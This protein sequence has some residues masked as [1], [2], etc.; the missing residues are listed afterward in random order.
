MEDWR[1]IPGVEI[2]GITGHARHGKDELARA[3]IRLLPGAERFALSDAV[4]AYGRAQGLMTHRNPAI[5]QRIGTHLRETDPDVWARCLYFALEDRRPEIAVITGVRY[6][7]ELA[8]IRGAGGRLVAVSR[9]EAPPLVDRDPTHPVEQ[10]IATVMAE[11]DAHFVIREYQTPDVRRA[12]F[13]HLAERLISTWI[14][15]A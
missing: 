2:I 5:L 13:D 7:N 11:A 1:P 4:A 12:F 3:L 8:M 6:P 10:S 9:P 14:V 15:A